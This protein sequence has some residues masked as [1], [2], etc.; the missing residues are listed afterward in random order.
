MLISLSLASSLISYLATCWRVTFTLY[1]LTISIIICIFSIKRLNSFWTTKSDER[2]C[3]L[4]CSWELKITKDV[5]FTKHIQLVKTPRFICI[6][7]A[8]R[9]GFS[10]FKIIRVRLQLH[11]CFFSLR[12]KW[13]NNDTCS[14]NFRRYH[15]YLFKIQQQNK[16]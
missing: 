8:P 7:N 1:D 9:R 3:H 10:T 5:Q 2:N 11:S 13:S 14:V 15:I 12:R 16:T 4:V 6:N